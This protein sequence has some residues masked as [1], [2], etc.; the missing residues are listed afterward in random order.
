MLCR[1]LCLPS[2]CNRHFLEVSNS[3]QR[4]RQS[5]RKHHMEAY[6]QAQLSGCVNTAGKLWSSLRDTWRRGGGTPPPVTTRPNQMHLHLPDGSPH[7]PSSGACALYVEYSSRRK[8]CARIRCNIQVSA[9]EG[10]SLHTTWCAA[11]IHARCC[12]RKTATKRRGALRGTQ[13]S[14]A[15]RM[16]RSTGRAKRTSGWW[17]FDAGC[18]RS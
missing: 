17:R 6:F 13:P 2:L 5:C 4:L 8:L 9:L 1:R 18:T 11:L 16:N 7:Q 14:A 10:P 15:R 12:V 3:V